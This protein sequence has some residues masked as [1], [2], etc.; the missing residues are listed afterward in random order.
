MLITTGGV[1]IRTR[2]AEIR[3]M[4]RATQGVTLINLGAEEKLAGLEKVVE[5]EE[6]G[7]DDRRCGSTNATILTK[8]RGIDDGGAGRR[9]RRRG[10]TRRRDVRADEPDLNPEE[11]SRTCASI[12]FQCRA[13]RCCRQQVLRA[14][15]RRDAR[16]AWQRHVGDG[17]EP[18]RQGVHVDRR[19]AEAD[20]RELLAI[21]AQLQGAV[22]AGRGDRAVRHGADEPA[23]RQ[24]QAP[25][26]S[27][28]AS[29]PRRR[30]G[31]R[32]SS[33]A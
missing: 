12:Q 5:T 7:A 30:S 21:P 26:T 17:D 18:P 2:V 9:R 14:G 19:S 13:R 23:A 10:A 4:S 15:A 27:T 11:R 24:E 6:N 29:G 33:A 31:K 1:L 20:L 8:R 25:T 32:R 28:P 3:E 22:P 16:L